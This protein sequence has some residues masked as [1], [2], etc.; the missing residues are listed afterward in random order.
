MEERAERRIIL[1]ELT[2]S[3]IGLTAAAIAVPCGIAVLT[4]ILDGPG[5]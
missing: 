2:L 5:Q 3:I 1:A 4:L